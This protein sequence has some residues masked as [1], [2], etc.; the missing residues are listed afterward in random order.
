MDEMAS[1]DHRVVLWLCVYTG[2]V[3]LISGM[4]AYAVLCLVTQSHPT[5]YNPTW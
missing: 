2:S 4:D 1:E 5:L 3:T